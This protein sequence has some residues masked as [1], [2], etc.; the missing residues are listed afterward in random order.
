[1]TNLFRAARVQ[2]PRECFDSALML[3][4]VST[5]GLFRPRFLLA[6]PLLVDEHLDPFFDLVDQNDPAL[7]VDTQL[8][9][10]SWARPAADRSR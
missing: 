5:L 9:L 2:T 1:M 8:H 10:K 6:S 7:E 4:D 3:N